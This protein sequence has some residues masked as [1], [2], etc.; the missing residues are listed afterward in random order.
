MG[1]RRGA[2]C[3]QSPEAEWGVINPS[4]CLGHKGAL[5]RAVRFRVMKE[6]WRWLMDFLGPFVYFIWARMGGN[7]H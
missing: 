4:M 7:E 6:S 2:S 3:F 1:T 5:V